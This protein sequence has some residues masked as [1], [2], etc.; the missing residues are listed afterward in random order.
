MTRA[1]L[2][3]AAVAVILACMA[4]IVRAQPQCAPRDTVTGQLA[5]RYGETRRGIGMAANGTVMEVYASAASGSWT[6]TVT[7]PDGLTCV[8]ASGEGFEAVTEALPPA[9]LPG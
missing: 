9:G 2:L 1:P 3:L 6:I 5:S 4:G 8:V 7:L